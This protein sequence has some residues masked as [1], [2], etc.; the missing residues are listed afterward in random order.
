[1]AEDPLEEEENADNDEI[2]EDMVVLIKQ[3]AF[4][5]LECTY[6]D[7]EKRNTERKYSVG[8]ERMCAS[9]C[10]LPPENPDSV[11]RSPCGVDSA[12]KWRP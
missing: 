2:A 12:P 1:M 11:P 6:C 5:F 4:L 9:K 10:P 3:G 7:C 8:E